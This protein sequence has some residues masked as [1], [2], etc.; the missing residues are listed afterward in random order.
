MIALKLGLYFLV[1]S[2]LGWCL[3]TLLR[4]LRRKRW[5]P[6]RA[7]P[8]SPLY[9]LC[10]FIFLFMPRPVER[11]HWPIQFLFFAIAFAGF[12]Y[13]A[14]ALILRLSG[15][16]I[17]DYRDRILHLHGHTDLF[18]FLLWGAVGVFTLRC[19]VPTVAGLIGLE[20]APPP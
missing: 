18:H 5:A 3:D 2:L 9:G 10:S 11:A 13:L 19:V 15:R 20:P 17:W 4:S 6:I 14:G 1:F 16:R 12:E 8:F 7:V